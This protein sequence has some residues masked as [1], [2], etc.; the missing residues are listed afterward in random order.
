MSAINGHTKLVGVIGWPVEHTVS[1]AMHNAAFDAAGLNWRYV[2]LRVHPERVVEAV[3]G[4]RALGFVGCNVTV[5]HKRAIM[6][7]M[8]EITDQARAIGAVNTITIQSDGRMVGHNT[9]ADGFL[10][11]LADGDLDPKGKQALVIGAGGAGRA[12]AYALA[13]SGAAVTILNRTLSR[14]ESL[15]ADLISFFPRADAEAR[16]YSPASLRQEAQSADLLV[17]ATPLGM[18]PQVDRS[19]WPD[20]VPM[21]P[22]LTVFDVVYN[23]PETKLMR[24]ARS[25]GAQAIGGLGMLVRQG[26]T[27]WELWTGQEAPV[28]VMAAAAKAALN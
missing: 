1:P 8:D 10:R 23:P 6:G 4:L 25:A 26:A 9:D 17:N 14:A 18:W 13:S 24:Q 11:A 16:P 7:S 20:E 21:L 5:P 15:V 22:S 27:A 19:P 12:V 2:P 3:R 28:E